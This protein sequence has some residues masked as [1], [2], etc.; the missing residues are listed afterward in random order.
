MADSVAPANCWEFK[1][2]DQRDCP[3][4]VR[5]LGR[6]CWIVSGTRRCGQGIA[7]DDKL[8][9]CAQCEF[10]KSVA[11]EAAPTPPRTPSP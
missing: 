4:Y 7:G 3:A 8:S 10:Y 1:H 2:C 5:G 6:M 11:G 9:E